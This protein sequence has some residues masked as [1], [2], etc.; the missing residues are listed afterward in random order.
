LVLVF[1]AFA[2]AAGMVAPMADWQSWLQAVWG[3]S[4]L[5][6]VT[7]YYFAALGLLPLLA[8]GCA[9][10]V[11]RSWANMPASRLELGT[12]FAY[13][14][15]PLGFAMWLS[16]YSFHLLTSYDTAIPALQRFVCDLGGNL[17]TPDWT[18][19]CCRPVLDWLLRTEIMIL[20]VG[21]LASLYVGYR[22]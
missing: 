11:S 15:V 14:L 20:D 16:H 13:A 1:G 7:A 5:F 22:I 9:T 17:G 12:R 8:V 2:N 18:A 19:S 4:P 6:S 21:L 10:S 3:H